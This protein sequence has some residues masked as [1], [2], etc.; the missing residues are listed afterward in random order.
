[1]NDADRFKLLHGPYRAPHLKRGDRAVCLFR[2]ADV[3]I[4][5]WS[6]APITWPRC[7]RPG[8]SGGSG[9][10]VTE[11]LIRAIKSESSLAIQH[12]FGVCEE[13]VWRW[14]KAFGVTQ[15]GQKARGGCTRSYLNAGRLA[16]AERSGPGR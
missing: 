1:V 16:F 14:R 12:W 3:V 4:T 11:E 2:D 8:Q 5:C 6:D 10:L 7:Q 13:V 15:W 9:L